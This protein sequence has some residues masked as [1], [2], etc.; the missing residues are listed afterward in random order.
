MTKSKSTLNSYISFLKEYWL[1]SPIPK[2]PFLILFV[3]LSIY[4][5]STYLN[6]EIAKTRGD[7][8][9]FLSLR[10]TNNFYKTIYYFFGLIF[11]YI[12]L[13]TISLYFQDYLSMI[14]RK[15]MTDTYLVKYLKNS[16]FYHINRNKD[17]DNPDQRISEDIKSFIEN[18]IK[19][20]FS[21]FNSVLQLFAYGFLLFNI[22]K[23]LFYTSI[24]LSILTN[25]MGTF[26]FGKK[27][28]FL[29]FEQYKKEADLRF[30]L[31]RVREHSESIA[32]WNG[33]FFEYLRSTNRLEKIIENTKK[34]I[35][36]KANLNF[37]QIGTKN[38]MNVFPT[39]LLSGLYLNGETEFGTIETGGIAFVSI[40]YALNVIIDLLKELTILSADV[41][42]IDSLN[43]P[44]IE[45]PTNQSIS[46]EKKGR[47]F[48][49]ENLTVNFLSTNTPL[50]ENFSMKI[51]EGK[52]LLIR[53]KS[54]VGKSTFLKTISGFHKN[55]KGLIIHPNLEKIGFLPQSDYHF[56]GSLQEIISYPHPVKVENRKKI[57]ELVSYFR[58]N[59]LNDREKELDFSQNLSKGEQQRLSLCRLF[60]NSPELVYLDEPASALDKENEELLFEYL[61]TNQIQYF[62][63]SHNND[64]LKFHDF[65]LLIENDRYTLRKI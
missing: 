40:M 39:L 4:T 35:F 23:L 2:K 38:L 1:F 61:K 21:F 15:G 16:D 22:S 8:M 48:C 7:F 44:P 41:S 25:A 52:N 18:S 64:F 51:P 24:L 47:E 56:K 3:I 28:S 55:G 17:I 46:Y 30:D 5:A 45:N 42:R 53:G 10:D 27:L 33:G 29:N 9:T 32:I 54:G 6:V 12:S 34:L 62:T 31:M 11:F 50:I 60:L 65:D 58:L 36:I 14:W 19:V 63:I 49:I 13:Y 26:I 43:D 57:D 20:F 37:F 59:F